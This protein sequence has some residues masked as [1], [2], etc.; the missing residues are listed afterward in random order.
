M[1]PILLS[2][3][4]LPHLRMHGVWSWSDDLYENIDYMVP[5]ELTED[6][7]A[8]AGT[9]KIY[10]RL[11]TSSGKHFEGTI[12]YALIAHEVYALTVMLENETYT[13]NKYLPEESW[14]DLEKLALR[15]DDKAEKMLPIRYS[16]VPK[17]LSIDAGFFSIVAK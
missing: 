6:G 12:T 15:I 1:E 5:V 4:G 3:F 14:Q 2:E 7:L 11:E 17:E 9:L 16:I 13:L 10:S 8:E